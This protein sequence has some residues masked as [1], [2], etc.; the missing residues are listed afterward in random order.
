MNAELHTLTGAYALHALSD[1]EREEFERHLG[2]CEACTQEVRELTA[3]AARLGLAVSVTPP[4]EMKAAALRRISTV[5]Q[6]PPVAPAPARP[7]AARF[8]GRRM[9]RFALAACMAV[10]AGS[11]GVAVW[12]HQSADDAQQQAR[13]AQQQSEQLA[14]V[15]AAP[16]AKATTGQLA[17][18]ASGTLV[19]AHSKNQ[20]VFV[21]SSMPKPP[22]GKVYQLWFNDAGTMRSAGLMDPS[23]TTEAVLLSGPVDKA[24]GMGITVEPSG[25]SPAPTSAPLALMNFAT[26]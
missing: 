22:S 20:A 15:L 2:D 24:S 25:G 21:A 17:G 12:Q 9:A 11:A 3:T 10:T 8:R 16:D 19:V 1:D 7:V 14:G 26:A 23:Q 5:R 4:P 6:E 18:G 13:A